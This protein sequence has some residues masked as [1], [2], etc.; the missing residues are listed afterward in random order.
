MLFAFVNTR[1]PNRTVAPALARK[2]IFPI[3][4]A[5]TVSP[6]AP[7]VVPSIVLEKVMFVPAA[8]VL[9]RGFPTESPPLR[10]RLLLLQ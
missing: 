10:K 5:L 9:E 1:D 2:E 6:S 3:L 7:L 4:P 8:A